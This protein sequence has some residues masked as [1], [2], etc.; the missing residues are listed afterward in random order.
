MKILVKRVFK[1]DNYTIGKLYV[2]DVLI[3]D[4]LEDKV[5]DLNDDGD[6]T[7]SGESKVYGKTAIPKGEYKCT[8]YRWAKINR[9]VLLLHNVPMFEGIL[10]HGGVDESHSLGCI[11]VGFNKVK[12]KLLNSREALDSLMGIVESKLK[13]NKK[14]EIMLTII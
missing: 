7:D 10:I 6:L 13:N 3:C 5:R 8:V 12:G 14:E 11:L 1:G 4:T 2:D 9:N